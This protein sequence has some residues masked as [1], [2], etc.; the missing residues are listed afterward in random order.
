MRRWRGVLAAATTALFV[1]LASAASPAAAVGESN[2]ATAG[3]PAPLPSG[4]VV[5]GG[6]VTAA[7]IVGSAGALATEVPIVVPTYHG[8]E[9]DLSLTY[10]SDRSNGWLGVGWALK[11]ESF[12]ERRSAALGVP[13]LAADDQFELDG[14]QLVACPR[15][16]SPSAAAPPS[17]RRVAP[18]PAGSQALT[19]TYYTTRDE[20]DLL[21][22]RWDNPSEPRTDRWEVQDQTGSQSWYEADIFASQPSGSAD[23][24]SKVLPIAPQQPVRFH[25]AWTQDL[26]GHRVDYTYTSPQSELDTPEL[27]TISYDGFNIRFYG[28]DRPDPVA[29]ATGSEVQYLRHRLR[30]IAV[31]AGTSLARAYALAYTQ[32]PGSGR[33]TLASIQTYGTKATV[34]QDG[35]VTGTPLP[36]QQFTTNSSLPD[37]LWSASSATTHPY[38]NTWTNDELDSY[39]TS[40]PNL[41]NDDLRLGR[42]DATD[43]TGLVAVTQASAKSCAKTVYVEQRVGGTASQSTIT[44][45]EV[46]AGVSYCD[47][48]EVWTADINGDGL[49]DLVF[50]VR[51][52]SG[53]AAVIATFL[54]NGHAGFS[55]GPTSAPV[56]VGGFKLNCAVGDVDGDGRAD[57]VCF[58]AWDGS[59]PSLLTTLVTTPSG[60]AFSSITTQS[61]FGPDTDSSRNG[62]EFWLGDVNGDGRADIVHPLCMT[63]SDRCTEQLAGLQTLLSSGD[64]HFG[65]PIESSADQSVPGWHAYLTDA[66]MADVNGDGL[67]D[68]AGVSYATLGNFDGSGATIITALALGDGHWRFTGQTQPAWAQQHSFGETAAQPIYPVFTPLSGDAAASLTLPVTVFGKSTCPGHT[69]DGSEQPAILRIPSNG[70]GTFAWPQSPTCDTTQLLPAA[71]DT[72]LGART[73]FSVEVSSIS[74]EAR[75]FADIDGDGLSDVLSTCNGNLYVSYTTPRHASGDGWMT[76]ALSGT[77]TSELVHI[78]PQPTDPVATTLR[79]QTPA[80]GCRFHDPR[81]IC[82]PLRIDQESLKTPTNPGIK[83]PLPA[84]HLTDWHALDTTGTGRSSLVYIDDSQAHVFGNSG[85]VPAT[86]VL[87]Y[88]PTSSGFDPTPQVTWLKTDPSLPASTWLP[89]DVEGDGRI[90][91]VS[92]QFQGSQMNVRSLYPLPHPIGGMGWIYSSQTLPADFVDSIRFRVADVNGDGRSDL[93][94]IAVEGQTVRTDTLLNEGSG[95]WTTVPASATVPSAD[96]DQ[97][98]WLVGDVNGDGLDDLVHV[99]TTDAAK[100]PTAAALFSTGNGK[101]QISSPE[102][103][104]PHDVA[105]GGEWLTWDATGGGTADLI[106]LAPTSI[107]DTGSSD[108]GA[109]I[110]PSPWSASGVAV[111]HATLHAPLDSSYHWLADDTNGDGTPDLVN[112]QSTGP[113]SAP[114]LVLSTAYAPTASDRLARIQNGIG[115]SIQVTYEP[116]TYWRSPSPDTACALPAGAEFSSVASLTSSDGQDPSVTETTSYSCPRWSPELHRVLGWQGSQVSQPGSAA[117]P[118]T[119]AATTRTLSENC[120]EQVTSETQSDGSGN[121]LARQ[122]YTYVSHGAGPS[123]RCAVQS[124][125]VHPCADGDPCPSDNTSY[126]YDDNGDITSEQQVAFSLSLLQPLESR[127]LTTTY[128]ASLAPYIVE[129]IQRALYPTAPPTTLP[130]QEQTI[131]YDAD[132][133]GIPAAPRGLPTQL[134][135]VDLTG[136]G[137]SRT[138]LLSYDADG[139]L[140]RVT[141][142]AGTTSAIAYDPTY[143][144]YPASATNPLGQQTTVGWDTTLGV[145]TS[146]SDPDHLT[147]SWTPDQYGRVTKVVPPVG[148]PTKIDYLDYGNPAKQQIRATVPDG[149]TDGLWSD[150]AFD[151]MGRPTI[152]TQKGSAAGTQDLTRTNYADALSPA[153]QQ[154]HWSLGTINTGTPVETYRYDALGRPVSE[155][156]PDGSATTWRYSSTPAGTVTQSVDEAGH[157]QSVVTDAWGRVASVADVGDTGPETLSFQYD[158]ADEPTTMSDTAHDVTTWTWNSLGDVTH[159]ADPDRGTSAYTYDAD[160][161]LISATDAR[162]LTT[163]YHYDALDRVTRADIPGASAPTTWSYDETGHGAA[164]GRLTSVTD[165]S[166]VGCPGGVSRNLDYDTSGR[167]ASVTTC[168]AGRPETIGYSYDAVGRVGAI[169]Y[170]DREQVTQQYDSGG[171]LDTVGRYATNATYDPSGQL[172]GLTLGNGLREQ[173]TVDP[174][175]G[176]STAIDVAGSSGSLYSNK[177]TFTE[178]GTVASSVTTPLDASQSYG[179]DQLNQLTSVSGLAAASTSYDS[180][181]SIASDSLNGNY[182]YRQACAGSGSSPTARGVSKIAFANDPFTTTFCYNADGDRTST[183]QPF[184]TQSITWSGSGEPDTITAN[185]FGPA[186]QASVNHLTYD[187]DGDLVRQTGVNP[188]GGTFDQ[189]DYNS[190]IEW[191]SGSGLVK[192]YLFGQT[193]IASTDTSGTHYYSSDALGSPVLVTDASGSLSTRVQYGTWGQAATLGARPPAGAPGFTGGAPIRDSDLVQLSARLYDPAHGQFISPDPVLLGSSDTQATNSYAYAGNDP[194]SSVDPSGL[195]GVPAPAAW[196]QQPITYPAPAGSLFPQWTAPISTG[197]G[198]VDAPLTFLASVDNLL[199]TVANVP[200]VAATGFNAA[201]ESGADWLVDHDVAS[202][203]TVDGLYFGAN[204]MTF[205]VGG[206]QQAFAEAA[207]AENVVLRTLATNRA[208]ELRATLSRSKQPFATSVLMDRQSVEFAFGDAGKTAPYFDAAGNQLLESA[209]A[210]LRERVPAQSLE[211]HPPLQCGE[212]KGCNTLLNAGSLFKN[213]V[214]TT[215]HVAGNYE[216]G[217]FFPA[218]ANCNVLLEGATEIGPATPP[219]SWTTIPVAPVPTLP[220]E[221]EPSNSIYVDGGDP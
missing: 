135:D 213:I 147:T 13:Q 113:I 89:A 117:R 10:E 195:D 170:P 153:Y 37:P 168:I 55:P 6:A 130:V 48:S 208:Q 38:P 126:T 68:F 115:G 219:P 106:Q 86:M 157:A 15:T 95:H 215:V 74:E 190:A 124:V 28:E 21:I 211:R 183:V 27:T 149:S 144:V 1:A 202:R 31:L 46:Q 127:V 221:L 63:A 167:V 200:F 87:T 132:C 101:W 96:A 91:L 2:T 174:T 23:L 14:E 118:A 105:P 51:N 178:D 8:L 177:A 139:N 160:D 188:N 44:M 34:A 192:R 184:D 121:V 66:Q 187:A 146:A 201:L 18:P 199:N 57:V 152:L 111:R 122:S 198:V 30:T 129:P 52:S 172:T 54:A 191:D 24:S 128:R 179:Y 70:D 73:F 69:K 156:H 93:V 4:P 110:V 61:P 125:A 59:S 22:T 36:A 17:C 77:G 47:T 39:E 58:R 9:P 136:A 33:S 216:P 137:A 186:G 120:G 43:S 97:G 3:G 60:T 20:Q 104:D 145:V 90:G 92:V 140:S 220:D 88:A 143:H 109:S 67:T 194:A 98:S 159:E 71:L 148:A 114:E 182:T 134:T 123:S 212:P 218:C 141:D 196:W 29:L 107:G 176:W 62:Y 25:L 197:L 209:N 116:S 155:T 138:T 166:G 193:V 72:C 154:T 7:S 103:I 56:A 35:S 158:A 42:F 85:L 119:R 189:R 131:C 180:A 210:S 41:S 84:R 65:A 12:I 108:L 16:S 5:S 80:P 112:V 45:P 133:A 207:S 161:N 75:G 83:F 163:T 185:P 99:N 206:V 162:G 150:Q 19:P 94:A 205:D 79:R 173:W 100:G 204:M 164:T 151:G 32:S 214:Y 142:P 181:D 165:P 64:G 217:V 49:S 40:I 203:A 78:D 76:A 175:R 53:T 82:Q 102:P 26:S 50:E 169:T 11:G 81:P 171:L